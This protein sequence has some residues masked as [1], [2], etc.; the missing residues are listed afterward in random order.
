[1]LQWMGGSR[2]KVTTSRKSTQKR[3]KQYFEQRKRQ[4]QLPAGLDSYADHKEHRSLD[5][6]S[7]SNL[8]TTAE[9]HKCVCPSGTEDVNINV[10]SMKY[11]IT[12][13]PLKVFTNSRTF[14]DNIE[15]EAGTPS[16]NQAETISPKNVSFTAPDNQ[17]NAFNGSSYKPGSLHSTADHEIS[18]FD[19]L[20]DDG[21]SG[22]LEG[23]PVNES[24]LAFSI[25]GLGKVGT[26]TPIHSPQQPGRVFQYGCPSPRKAARRPN[27]S[28]N[29]DQVLDDFELEVDLMMQDMNMP[30]SG[31]SR[32]QKYSTVND[33]APFDGHDSKLKSSFGDSEVFYGSGNINEDLWHARPS[34]IDD[35]F[36]NEKEFAA[37]RRKW[38]GQMEVVDSFNYRNEISDYDFECSHLHKNRFSVKAADRYNILDSPFP[39]QQSSENNGDF[40]TSKTTR[41]PKAGG[42]FDFRQLIHQQDQSYYEDARDNLSLLS[43]ES[44]SSTAV[45]GEAT[46]KS[47]PNSTAR[48]SRRPKDT[49]GS[50]E[51]KYGFR[52]MYA[53]ETQHRDSFDLQQGSY[54]CGSGK[55]TRMP[56]PLKPMSKQFPNLNSPFQVRF[57]QQENLLF[58]EGYS[59][60]AV[61]PDISSFC[62]TS[63][64]IPSL[65]SKPQRQDPFIGFSV[66]VS[67]MGTKSSVDGSKHN[68]S[69][70]YS[71][72]GGTACEKLP[73]S[74]MS[75]HDSPMFQNPEFVTTKTSFSLDSEPLPSFCVSRSCRESV[76][77]DLSEQESV[78]KDE[79]SKSETQPANSKN[80]SGIQNCSHNHCSFSE[81][82]EIINVSDFEDII[83]CNEA[84]DG[85]SA[86]KGSQKLPSPDP[87]H[88]GEASSSVKNPDKFEHVHD[89]DQ[90]VGI[91]ICCQ[92][93][94]EE[95]DDAAPER[96][97][98][99]QRQG[100]CPDSSSPV[101]MLESY[102][103][104]FLCVQKILKD[105]SELDIMKEV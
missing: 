13:G 7:L 102:V 64:A 31:S 21:P 62:Q 36:L 25:E 17:N 94:I 105:S 53:E 55:C 26:Q 76:F 37:S 44:C 14:A 39:K 57:G 82:K 40:I 19:L 59:S 63:E 70:K 48:Q 38:P 49:F 35:S 61:S 84:K 27:L 97:I 9:E 77:P 22:S 3:Q 1:M 20:A 43:E 99:S 75:C 68:K 16:G 92:N 42:N 81:N 46:N 60:A 45:R 74:Y 34:F 80:E 4:Q 58:E 12:K 52:N 24:H 87:E 79:G 41:Y 69:I 10:P 32:K 89:T 8:S 72:L 101:M 88:L 5:V 93:E 67:H 103:L 33:S 50:D 65:G 78:S 28:K 95:I 15:L 2:R 104:Q 96:K 98:P 91:P 11:P 73:L 83:K 66:P 30:L 86:Q 90:N 23:S 85:T 54:T 100:K 6:L 71:S 47:P 51:N 18:V 29:F 56:S